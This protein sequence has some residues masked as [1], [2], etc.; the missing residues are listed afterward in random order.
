MNVKNLIFVIVA[1]LLGIFATNAYHTTHAA[2]SSPIYTDGYEFPSQVY[3]GITGKAIERLSP[4]DHVKESQIRVYEDHV[5]LQIED[6]IFAKFTDTNSMDPFLD[7][8]SNALEVEPKHPDEVNEGDI[9]AYKNSCTDGSVIIHQ[10]IKKGEDQLGTY[11]L[12]K[13]I[14]NPEVDKCKIRFDEIQSV[15]VAIIY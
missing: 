10:V 5:Q 1:F 3:A 6:A 9:I 4:G 7:E 8:G 11:Y 13:G 15:L 2:F 14:N 12:A